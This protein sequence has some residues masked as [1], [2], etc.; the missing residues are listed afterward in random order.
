MNRSH[1]LVYP[2]TY[3]VFHAA[4]KLTDHTY[5]QSTMVTP[6]SGLD[7]LTDLTVQDVQHFSDLVYAVRHASFGLPRAMMLGKYRFVVGEKIR[8]SQNASLAALDPILSL[9]LRE[10][11]DML[12]LA[13]PSDLDWVQNTL[14]ITIGIT[15]AEV[16]RLP[17]GNTTQA[18]MHHEFVELS[19]DPVVQ[20]AVRTYT[21]SS[22]SSE[23]DRVK[24]YRI[25]A[26]E[27]D[28]IPIRT[29]LLLS[30]LSVPLDAIAGMTDMRVLVAQAGMKTGNPV[31]FSH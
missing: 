19:H 15:A 29:M 28:S 23:S 1:T 7:E 11:I 30:D 9:S 26:S 20:L 22:V 24:L 18:R 14:I 4:C 10:R 16:E 2:A 27:T 5:L 21:F 31:T 8:T 13:D 3:S 17:L 6:N 25:L 12:R